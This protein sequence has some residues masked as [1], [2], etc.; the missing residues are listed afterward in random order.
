M[1]P[2]VNMSDIL[3]VFLCIG[4]M[5]IFPVLTPPILYLTYLL[6]I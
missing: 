3:I 6:Y 5:A 1:G 2:C 4:I